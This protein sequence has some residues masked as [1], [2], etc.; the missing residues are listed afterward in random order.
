[1]I[2]KLLSYIRLILTAG[3]AVVFYYLIYFAKFNRHPDKYSMEY[4]YKKVRKLVL[5]V[6][7][8]FRVDY[9]VSGYDKFL[10]LQG[11]CLIV[12]NHQSDADPLVMIA[13]HEKPI[14]FI[15]KKE[16]FSFPFI[17]AALKCLEG[18]S[19][20]RE[21]LMNQISQIRDIVAHLKDE[22][23]PNIVVYIEGTRNKHPEDACLPFH[24]GTLKIAKMAGVKVVPIEIYS[25]FRILSKK[26]YLKHYPVFLNYDDPIDYSKYEKF[27]SNEEANLLRE[28]FDKKIDALRKLDL[29]Y[30]YNLKMSDKHKA[31]ETMIDIKRL[32]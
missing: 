31:L 21:N 10:D 7:K 17:G 18:F 3:V 16:A 4:R 12:S 32:P 24:A 11:K 20:D 8:C 2:K 14:T 13:K 15:A 9:V 23:K 26:H 29:D 25:T 28:T 19:L 1:M 6:L 27:E 22:S 5:Y 30:I